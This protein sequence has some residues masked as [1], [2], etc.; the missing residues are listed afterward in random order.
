MRKT[1]H[2]SDLEEQRVRPAT[3]QDSGGFGKGLLLA[4]VS[5][6]SGFVTTC[7][8]EFR[9]MAGYRS[10]FSSNIERSAFDPQREWINVI[11]AGVSYRETTAQVNEYFAAGVVYRNYQQGVYRDDADFNLDSFGE[12]F[13]S[14]QKLSWVA[15]DL[16]GQVQLDPTRPDT[17]DNREDF[18]VIATGPNVYVPVGR[19]DTLQLEAR[20][21]YLWVDEQE[22]DNKRLAF[23][24]RWL[25]RASARTTL[26]LNYEYLDVKFRDDVLNSNYLRNDV[27]LRSTFDSGRSQLQMDL[28]TTWL[29]RDAGESLDGSLFRVRWT[30]RLSSVLATGLLYSQEYSDTA[31]ELAPSGI[32][33]RV[34]PGWAT[35]SP[36]TGVVAS[37][38]FYTERAEIILTNTF[39]GI[40]MGVRA[41]TNDITYEVSQSRQ[42][43]WG[44]WADIGWAASASLAFSASVHRIVTTFTV[45][46]RENQDWEVSVGATYRSSLRLTA[47]LSLLHAERSS[48]DPGQEYFDNRAMFTLQYGSIP[49]TP[50]ATPFAAS[51]AIENVP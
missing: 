33:S 21:G 2:K 48:S 15:A 44:A 3:V 23:A 31:L 24:T 20:Y 51:R 4:T 39:S 1:K 22:L 18:N 32:I 49:L 47:A 34:P 41:Y 25:H 19:F 29:D 27:F 50:T 13:L 38:P 11:A 30:S 6:A 12:W 36:G 35:L 8:A 26:S 16:Y 28:G 9:S 7:Y 10:E 43:Q 14:P 42:D 40:P 37:E 46:E 17:P 45:P 5:V